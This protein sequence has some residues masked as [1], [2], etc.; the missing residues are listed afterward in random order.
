MGLD[1]LS[2]NPDLW[3]QFLVQSCMGWIK[4]DIVFSTFLHPCISGETVRTENRPQNRVPPDQ[5]KGVKNAPEGRG[6]MTI[7]SDFLDISGQNSGF[8][9]PESVYLAKMVKMAILAQNSQK[10]LF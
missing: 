3:H 7:F 8:H 9:G 5:S 1:F 10:W 6:K 2:E 4:I